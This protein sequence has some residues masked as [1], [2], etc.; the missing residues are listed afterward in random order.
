MIL[1]TATVE[2]RD[3]LLAFMKEG[4]SRPLSLAVLASRAS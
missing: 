4:A 2:A 1:D 3:S